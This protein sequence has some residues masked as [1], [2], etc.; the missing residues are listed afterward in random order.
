MKLLLVREAVEYPTVLGDP[1]VG[2]GKVYDDPRFIDD[3]RYMPGH[4]LDEQSNL[5]VS[6]V[7][8]VRETDPAVSTRDCWKCRRIDVETVLHEPLR[9]FDRLIVSCM[10]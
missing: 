2:F 1:G 10:S 4:R 3:V 8:S 6:L 9:Q 5:V 7:Q